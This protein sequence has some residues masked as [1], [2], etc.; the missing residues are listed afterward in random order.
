MDNDGNLKA[1]E[2][3]HCAL[4]CVSFI[5]S[6]DNIC[7]LIICGLKPKL[8]PYINS[9]LILGYEFCDILVNTVGARADGEYLNALIYEGRIVSFT[10]GV[11]VSIGVR[12]IL[13][14]SNEHIFFLSILK[15]ALYLLTNRDRRIDVLPR[16]ALTAVYTSTFAAFSVA[17]GAGES[18]VD[19]YLAETASVFPSK[20]FA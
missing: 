2:Y 16:T 3:F 14:V 7:S 18:A 5:A 6:V 10:Q 13:K 20:I 19:A 17:V 15:P 1:L 11:R 4:K 12:E 8:Y 9:V